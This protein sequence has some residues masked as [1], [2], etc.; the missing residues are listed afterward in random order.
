MVSGLSLQGCGP[1]ESG[2]FNLETWS[3]RPTTRLLN[4]QA[5]NGNYVQH[6]CAHRAQS[7]N[8]FIHISSCYLPSS[9]ILCQHQFL[10][11]TFIGSVANNTC[12]H[13][14]PANKGKITIKTSRMRAC[15][16]CV[17]ATVVLRMHCGPNSM[18][19][20]P[21]HRTCWPQTMHKNKHI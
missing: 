5:K 3:L 16:C 14:E 13:K 11:N 20:W 19:R 4:W 1:T 2:G 17:H 10:P 9:R 7:S 12:S 8:H 21:V 6:V 15:S 18:D